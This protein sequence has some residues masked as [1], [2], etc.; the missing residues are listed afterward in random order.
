MQETSNSGEG[1]TKIP[2]SHNEQL[3]RGK[4][5]HFPLGDKYVTSVN[6]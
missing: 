2:A 1:E 6:N 4:C 3:C 5:R